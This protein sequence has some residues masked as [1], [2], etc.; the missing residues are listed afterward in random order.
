MKEGGEVGEQ[1]QGLQEQLP[2]L[3]LQEWWA[4]RLD[5]PGSTTGKRGADKLLGCC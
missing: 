4:D 1:L 5:R 3:A 2:Q